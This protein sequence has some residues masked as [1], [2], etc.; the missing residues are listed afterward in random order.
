MTAMPL[1]SLDDLH[2]FAV[3]ARHLSFQR[4][5]AE[6]HVTPSAVSHRMKA[7]EQ[8]LDV[9][10]FVRLTRRLELTPEGAALALAVEDGVAR[11]RHG[12][13]ALRA[14]AADGPLTVGAPTSFATRWLLPRLPR[15]AALHPGIPVTL[16]AEDRLAELGRDGIDVA[17]RF[18]PG[19]YP[20]LD[21]AKLADDALF[22]VCSPALLAGAP[23]REPAD[24]LSR[25]LLHDVVAAR[26]GS[27]CG[28][29]DW[30]A[31][32]GL[33]VPEAGPRFSQAH[34]ALQAACDGQGVA[35]AR[36]SLVVDDLA[37]GR[38]VRPLARSVPPRFAYFL[39]CRPGQA[40][41]PRIRA[42]RDWLAGAVD[43]AA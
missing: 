35:L 16:A 31:G 37:A 1:P 19:R 4:A 10:L 30:L 8:R 2:C 20:G 41:H 28:W 25:P 6:L 23:V 13:E 33:A 15:F 26:D 17:V 12:V 22:P 11:I 27:G 9:R 43:W 36:A 38:L 3:A 18:G 40:G 42:F 5:A 29:A 7:L 34:L 24:L 21:A 32:T 39:V 14:P